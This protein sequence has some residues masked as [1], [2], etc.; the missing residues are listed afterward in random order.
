MPQ[1][2]NNGKQDVEGNWACHRCNKVGTKYTKQSPYPKTVRVSRHTKNKRVCN[3]CY[4]KLR[5]GHGASEPKVRQAEYS[6]VKARCCTSMCDMP[7][8]IQPHVWSIVNVRG[9]RAS[10][11]A[12]RRV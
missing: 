10:C 7:L 2:E 11:H 8:C 6:R 5:R 3:A 4:N 9:P 1:K 12:V